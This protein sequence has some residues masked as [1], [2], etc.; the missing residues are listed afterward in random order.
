MK[1]NRRN[2]L[3]PLLACGRHV[4]EYTPEAPDVEPGTVVHKENIIPALDWNRTPKTYKDADGNA[5]VTWWNIDDTLYM[6]CNFINI[7]PNYM[8]NGRSVGGG[9]MTADHFKEILEYCRPGLELSHKKG[10]KVVTSLPMCLLYI[11]QYD[12]AGEDW[13]KLAQ[14][15]A[16][17]KPRVDT[18]ESNIG[19]AC[20]NN[21]LFKEKIRK[22]TVMAAEAG[23]DG[24]FYDAGPYS[25]GVRFNCNCEYC[26]K[27]WAKL[28]GE[29]FGKKVEMPSRD[30]ELTTEIGRLLWKWRHKIFID[31][32][33]ELRDECRTYNENFEVWPNIGMNAT[34]SCFYTL[35]GLKTSM[36]EYNSNEITNPGVESTLYFFSQ[37]EAENP[38]NP[39]IMEFCDI[40][41]Q[42]NPDYKFYTAFV[43]A[44]AGAGSVMASTSQNRLDSFADF[45]NTCSEIKFADP[46][47]F[48]DS[49][50]IAE[51]AIVYSWQEINAC[52]LG[53]G[54]SPSFEENPPRMAA[55]LLAEQG[56]P[57]DYIM[58]EN[59]TAAARLKQYKTL[60]FADFDILD[61]HFKE[62]VEEF[63]KDGG[64]VIILGQRFAKQYTVDYGVKYRDWDVDVFESWTGKTFAGA[65]K[66]KTGETF[67]LG[68]GKIYVVKNY[69]KIRKPSAEVL[70]V[71]E[72]SGLYD[73]V[74]VTEDIEG[75]V[76]TTIRSD[77]SNKRWWLSCIT[78][79]SKG[80]YDD[81]P[82]TIEVRLPE[83]ETVSAV[84][85]V[86]PTMTEE[87]T[88]LSWKQEGSKLTITATIGLWTMFKIE[89]GA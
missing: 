20:V 23:Y 70:N 31:F 17:G 19:Y 82:I 28:T 38:N 51:T 13:T 53:L 16:D 43:E 29:Y 42:A 72:T 60:I 71:F 47:A 73:F 81:K 22:C 49:M 37:Y 74:K 27:A 7:F 58:P 12:A 88:G 48:C 56:I 8:N 65:D 32:L 85:G 14:I 52:H 11:D 55:S 9:Q 46:D 84:S 77:A 78:Y 10:I 89:K 45:V 25:Y 69:I 83:G 41:T 75:N 34:H 44:L 66:D 61:K 79:A 57:Y 30:P 68:S 4:D 36:C 15:T 2:I 26:K 21:P 39:L 24:V 6:G 33:F 59:T 63:I 80:V 35:E 62:L 64:N 3:M 87:Q 1:I 50:S 67:T 76:E 40:G 54:E 86:S 5:V 18:F